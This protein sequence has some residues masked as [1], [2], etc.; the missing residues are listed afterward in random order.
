MKILII[1]LVNLLCATSF[2]TFTVAMKS[3][4]RNK[5]FKA[6]VQNVILEDLISNMAFDGK[7]FKI[8]I[9]KEKT[10]I[11][12]Q[13]EDEETLLRAATVYYH[14]SKARR[15]FVEK[16]G[17]ERA[18][19]LHKIT[20][21]LNLTNQFSELG[22]FSHEKQDPQYNNALTVPSGQ[23]FQFEDEVIAPWDSEIW[24]RPL[25]K[26]HLNEI[27]LKGERG[28][29]ATLSG[30]RKQL[31]QMT[32]QR[33]LTELV[34]GRI[35]EGRSNGVESLFRVAGASLL[36]ELLFRNDETVTYW[37]TRKWYYLDA[38]MVPEIIYH[39]YA[40]MALSDELELSH[41]SPVIEGMADYFASTIANSKVLAGKIKKYNSFKGKKAKLKDK[42]NL[43]YE[44]S[45]YANTDFVFGILWELKEIFG[46]K[47]ANKVVYNL[48]KRIN[49]S[50]YIRK[51]LPQKCYNNSVEKEPGEC[52]P[53]LLQAILDE[54]EVSCSKP[55]TNKMDLIALFNKKG[56]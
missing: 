18:K 5:K 49:T 47:V 2:A 11:S 39:E 55:F 13:L 33:F 52:S 48:R 24:F 10:P 50:S 8:V 42:Y 22:H 19:N 36:M 38:A 26:F 6:K 46:E 12:F 53:N 41:S 34:T 28:Y 31:H 30:F 9:G 43:L 35:N 7:Y 23:G 32:F 21:R 17:S 20:V 54:C 3:V 45:G 40:H 1:I 27:Q 37:F 25:K 16:L 4:V 51:G 14:L 29:F 15:F 56:F 44:T